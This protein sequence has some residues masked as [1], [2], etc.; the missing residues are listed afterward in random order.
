MNLAFFASHRGSN[1]QVVI[2]ACKEERLQA[3]PCVVISNNSRAE[4]LAR[5][6]QEGIPHYHRS[7][8]THPDPAQLDAEVLRLLLH[9]RTDLVVLA[10]YMRKL[11]P[12]TLAEYRGRVINIHPA[13]LPKYGGRGMYGMHVHNAVLAAGERETGVTIHL[14]DEEYD[15]GAIIAQTHVAVLETDTVETLAQ[16][17]L[18]IEHQF[19]VETLVRV[20]SGELAFSNYFQGS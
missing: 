3:C 11:G 2:D 7:S 13:L 20:T 17:V 15:Q 14:V 12:K 10:G 9:H 6:R 1:M 8:K 16:R 19:L 18:E 4:A 5:A